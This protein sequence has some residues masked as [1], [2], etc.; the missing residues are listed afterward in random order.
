MHKKIS[1]KIG[2]EAGFGIMITGNTLCRVLT[3]AGFW[4][5][6]YPEYPSL[7]R[8]GHNTYQID[9]STDRVWST[10]NKI[11]ILIALNKETIELHKEELNDK[12]VLIY[13]SD[14][15][16]D[17]FLKPVMEMC[18]G[19]SQQVPFLQLSK[20]SGSD[21]L[22]KNTVALGALMAVLN[23]DIKYINEVLT[24]QFKRKGEKVIKQNI[25]TAKKGY[26]FVKNNKNLQMRYGPSLP[27]KNI[28]R[29]VL[30]LNEAIGLGSIASGCKFF[31]AYPMTPINGLISFMALQAEKYGFI[32]KQPE[33]E[34]AAI[35]MAIGAS[36]A[37]VRSLTATSGGGFSLM[38]EAFGMAG[39]TETPIVV[40]MGQ[41]PGPSSGLPTW[42]GQG[43]LNFMLHASQGEFLRFVLAPGDLQEAFDLTIEAF[44]IA[45]IYQTP[46]VLLI[47][48]YLA[49]SCQTTNQFNTNNIKINR[50]K[51]LTPD[52]FSKLAD[53]K[54]YEN[55]ND[56][57]SPRTYP[58]KKGPFWI[59]NSYEHDEYGYSTESAKQISEMIDKRMRKE[60]TAL[61]N[62]PLPQIFGPPK[63]GITYVGWGS[64]KAPVMEALKEINKEKDIANYLHFSYLCPL[65]D[66][67]LL[68]LLK[69]LN[70]LILVE[71]NSTGQLGRLIRE[72]TGVEITNRFLK[73]DGRPFFPSEIVDYLK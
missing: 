6:G 24:N 21:A 39:M 54:R 67:K 34:I 70:K 14:D 45:D 48:K 56:G 32:Y 62:I 13:D 12:A 61:P 31:S 27:S 60:K 41:R 23:L 49:E 68:K 5:F 42:S 52:Q 1:I 10:D 35:N 25:E 66:L 17:E 40:V 47:D 46:V 57:I 2:G 58:G 7:I 9:Y 29:F 37:G 22:M 64:T 20:E 51:I 26:E 59:A 43:D 28:N 65:N 18:H 69:S 30:T 36:Y 73:Y 11:D 38:T 4:T 15:N 55:T 63:A 53:Y 33:D 71:G 8:G 50:G 72:K 3:R 19:T 44:N 16:D